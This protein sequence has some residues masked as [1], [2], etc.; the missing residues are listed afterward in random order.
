MDDLPTDW[1]PK[2]IILYLVLPP[3]I[4]LDDTLIILKLILLTKYQN[5]YSLNIN[6]GV[7]IASLFFSI[8]GKL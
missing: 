5:Y 8:I 3:P 4:V 7:F 1:S 2:N 6:N